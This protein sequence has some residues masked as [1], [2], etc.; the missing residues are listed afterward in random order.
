[1]N[2]TKARLCYLLL[3]IF[4]IT[5]SNTSKAQ[6]LINSLSYYNSNYPVEK[7]YVQFDKGVYSEGETIWFKAYLSSQNFPSS[8]STNFYAELLD[9]NGKLIT[10]KMLPVFEATAAGNFDI[11]AHFN[12]AGMVFRA[13]TAWQLNFDSSS[14]FT[15]FIPLATT[16]QQVEHEKK[17]K[18]FNLRFFP[19][20]G[21]MLA[22]YESVLAFNVT[23]ENGFPG[24]ASGVIKEP[25]GKI[26]TSFKTLHDG[27]GKLI[28]EPDL[29]KKYYAEWKD[30]NG[31]MHDTEL[32]HPK[33]N[34]MILQVVNNDNYVGYVLKRSEDVLA[35]LKRVHLVAQ[36]HQQ[37]LY[38]AAVSLEQTN[39]ISGIIKT[40]SLTT[41]ILQITVFDNEWN[42]VAERIVF[43]NKNDYSMNA[44]IVT[45]TANLE[46]RGKNILVIDVPDTISSNLSL[47]I[48]D[49][50]L[51]TKT[52][53]DD[54]I[55]GFL[56]SGDLRGYIHNPRY[57]FSSN[58]DSVKQSIDLLMLTHGWRKYDWTSLAAN[59]Y[60]QI[61]YVPDR[62]LTLNGKVYGAPPSQ[63]QSGNAL[64]NLIMQTKDSARQ[65]IFAPLSKTG[66]FSVNG[67]VFYDTV[68]VFYQFNSNNKL[69]RL[70]TVDFKIAPPVIIK[71]GID[72]AWVAHA[73]SMK[74]I[75]SRTKYFAEKREEVIPLLNKKI[76]TLDE[77]IVRSKT[78]NR[79]DQ[80]EKKYSS[81]LFQ[82]GNSRSFNL[83]DDPSAVTSLNALNYL[84]G[85]VAGLQIYGSGSD[86]TAS[87]R[88]GT[89]AF[90]LDEMPVDIEEISLLPVSE[91]AMIKVFSPPFIGA[92]GN[93]AGGAIAVYRKK[94]GDD[95]VKHGSRGLE[96]GFAIGYTPVKQFYSPDYSIFSPLNEV[97][98][99]RSTLLWEPYILTDKS[100]RKVRV[101]FY[102]NDV[103]T[104]LRVVLEGMNENGHLTHIEK[105]ITR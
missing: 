90:F 98:D 85:K 57:Y 101:V 16:T 89:P 52:N 7:T 65:F 73:A 54:I 30:E 72:T 95:D 84:Q 92:F 10:R 77:V 47:S 3:T 53:E 105:L 68:S 22:D 60:P 27:M 26:L 23:D 29:N 79:E 36:M 94:G 44:S 58:S 48:T 69:N 38:K 19:E 17:K 78:R 31:I 80:L 50:G 24:E 75:D 87:W 2:L 6:E 66:D 70:A 59:K 12:Q 49:A 86:Y 61:K 11:P 97:E 102:N 28:F 91:I 81:G 5:Y 104:S 43:V 15:R 40:D 21:D 13:Y 103:S 14:I 4:F 25:S 64:I 62:Y 32:P 37:I 67:L 39:I 82:S 74:D 71:T 35:P 51:Q 76:K 18:N 9:T 88:S 99:V 46:K 20:G 8:I 34:G 42:P 55:S 100:N 93:G 96:K 41:G 56:L 1:M 33:P 45:V 63:L 83:L